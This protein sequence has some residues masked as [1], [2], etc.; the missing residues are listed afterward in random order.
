MV[1]VK[2]YHEGKIFFQRYERGFP[3]EDVKI[4]GDSNEQGTEVLFKPDIEIFE[5]IVFN[6]DTIEGRIKE[7]AFLIQD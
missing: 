6:Y 4:I 7:L 1:E 5:S 3:K 2:V